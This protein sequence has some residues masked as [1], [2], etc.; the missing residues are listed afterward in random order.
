MR[1]TRSGMRGFA[2]FTNPDAWIH[3]AF[4]PLFQFIMPS[5][6]RVGN[7]T[8]L[9]LLWWVF[10]SGRSEVSFFGFRGSRRAESQRKVL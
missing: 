9:L 2:C 10:R 5:M 7:G 8:K 4:F 1:G 3:P 6:V